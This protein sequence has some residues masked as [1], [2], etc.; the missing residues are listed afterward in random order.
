MWNRIWG[1]FKKRGSENQSN[2]TTECVQS[3]ESVR[4]EQISD[5]PLPK[6]APTSCKMEESNQEKCFEDQL[7][8][9]QLALLVECI[10][11][12]DAHRMRGEKIFLWLVAAGIETTFSLFSQNDNQISMKLLSFSDSLALLDK[13][14]K[15]VKKIRALCKEYSRP[16]PVE[17]RLIFDLRTEKLDVAYSYDKDLFKYTEDSYEVFDEWVEEEKKKLQA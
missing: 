3:P 14:I 15:Y 8:D 12:M 1:I 5:T 7:M 6:T 4:S 16:C 2:Q 9:L 13:G 11:F 17:S 10:D